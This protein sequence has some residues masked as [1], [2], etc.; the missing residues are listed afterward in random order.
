MN[1]SGEFILHTSCFIACLLALHQSL[2]F[3]Y[4]WMHHHLVHPPISLFFYVSRDR[5][6][7]LIKMQD[8]QS[9]LFFYFIGEIYFMIKGPVSPMKNFKKIKKKTLC[10]VI[11]GDHNCTNPLWFFHSLGATLLSVVCATLNGSQP[12]FFSCFFRLSAKG[13]LF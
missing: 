2:S 7:L 11:P 5:D 4:P 8:I 13:F 6:E 9:F 10:H 1:R 3:R 12:F